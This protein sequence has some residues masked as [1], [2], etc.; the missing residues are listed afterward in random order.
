MIAS[1]LRLVVLQSK[2]RDL[3]LT[4]QVPER[5]LELRLLDEKIMFRL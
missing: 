3:F 1:L 4:H 2:V 5:V